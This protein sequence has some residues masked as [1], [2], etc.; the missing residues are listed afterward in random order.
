MRSLRFP[1]ALSP[2]E[3]V[4]IDVLKESPQGCLLAS[5]PLLRNYGNDSYTPLSN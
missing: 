3:T 4:R 5:I 1:G 2:A